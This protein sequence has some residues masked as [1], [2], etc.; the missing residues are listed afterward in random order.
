MKLFDTDPSLR[1]L[2]CMTHPDDE[3]S[4]CAWIQRLVR[5]GN[6][7][8][9]S[10]THSNPTREAEARAV[11]H[12]L[13]VPPSRLF[14][15]QATDGSACNEIPTLLPKFRE[16]M[17][18][19]KPD[20]VCC[21]AFEQGHID[22]D[23]TN[24]LVNH[25]F[26][27]PVLEIPFYHTYTTRL[28]TMNRF[29]DPRGEEVLELEMDERRLKTMIARQFPSQNIWSVL[30]WYEVWQKAR[31]RPMALTKTER[32]RLQT[33]HNFLRPNHPPR[34][35]KKIRRSPTWRRWRS[36]MRSARRHMAE[37]GKNSAEPTASF[38]NCILGPP[39]LRSDVASQ[40]TM[41][42]SHPVPMRGFTLIELL[43]VIAIIG[44][45]AALLFPVFARA[46]AAAGDAKTISNARQLGMAFELYQES[47]DD[48]LPQAP[49]GLPGSN[50]AGGWIN[51][52][53]F[54]GAEA[55]SF[56]PSRGELMPYVKTSEIYKSPADKDSNR[57]AN[58]FAMNGYLTTWTGN[59]MNPGKA[60]GT[61][62]FPAST[63]LLGEEGCGGPKLVGYGYSNGTNDGYFNPS[64][65][66]FAKFHP[67]GAAVVFTDGHAKI[68]Q[69]EDHFDETI[70]G[71]PTP[72]YR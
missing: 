38:K 60:A 31:L 49:D 62:E 64:T 48:V 50:L 7:V 63:M 59:G 66:H 41:N 47:W 21:G 72:C 58:S 28:Q 43:V 42:Q 69:A 13:G 37:S 11:A 14:F 53:V 6:P 35:A 10:W 20:R 2:F 29:S 12:L 24:F 71:T 68:I 26:A 27:G 3:I 15:Y 46:K 55:G 67:A 70:C 54:G 18:I 30:L 1:W 36:A 4:I 44:I 39:R 16:M 8:Y 56:I 17:E 19:V 22:H 25:S 33:H 32:M 5:N 51:Y 52:S 9:M 23:T 65:D 34:I 57:S 45:L 61:I 40:C